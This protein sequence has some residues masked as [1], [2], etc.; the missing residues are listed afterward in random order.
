MAMES[1]YVFVDD[2][3][4]ELKR[5]D[6]SEFQAINA[7][8]IHVAKQHTCMISKEGL[9]PDP[10]GSG[11]FVRIDNKLFVAT[12]KHLFDEFNAD[13]V[14]GVYW[15]QD[16]YRVGAALSSIIFDKNLD[17]AAIP[18]ASETEAC[19]QPIKDPKHD[20]HGE[21]PDLFVISGIPSKKCDLDHSRCL[22]RSY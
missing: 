19:A 8:G 14:I 4:T 1:Y 9:H 16:D 12:A 10:I 3:G 6:E 22:F 20:Q 18:L 13:D 5:V 7:V 11:T 2:K 17:L 21:D 15:G